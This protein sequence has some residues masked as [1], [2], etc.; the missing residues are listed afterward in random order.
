MSRRLQAFGV[1]ILVIALVPLSCDH[2]RNL[3]RGVLTRLNGR[4]TVATRLAQYGAEAAARWRPRFEDAGVHWPP[5][6]VNLAAFKHERLLQVYA[7]D[8]GDQQI[9][10]HTYPILGASGTLGP[11]LREGDSQV[12]E[13]LYRIESLNPNSRFHLS[14]R[15]SYPNEQDRRQAD[16]DHRDNLGGDIM[17]HGGTASIGCL[18]MGDEAAED[19]FVLA[20][21]TGIE[22]TNVILSPV[23][24]R[25]KD[26][27]EQA[28]LPADWIARRYGRIVSALQHLHP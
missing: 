11:K 19:L 9:L 26:Y 27:P 25:S 18:A 1:V 28:P 10:I 3:L 22:H 15:V 6:A 5:S 2:G 14:L 12:P 8:R 20:A 13:G 21:E 23:D 24:F 7:G 4:A 17:I 16:V